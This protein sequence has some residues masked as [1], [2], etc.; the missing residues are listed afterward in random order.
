MPSQRWSQLS[1]EKHT[2]GCVDPQIIKRHCRTHT[3]AHCWHSTTHLTPSQ[4]T[5]ARPY[6]H[7]RWCFFMA[8]HVPPSQRHAGF[9][10]TTDKRAK[11]LYICCTIRRDSH[12]RYFTEV[13]MQLVHVFSNH[14]GGEKRL[15]ATTEV[16]A[17]QSLTQ[18][19]RAQQWELVF[20]RKPFRSF[21]KCVQYI[22]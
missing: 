13:S 9:F 3:H 17:K 22:F 15:C 18:S 19:V 10:C 4:N 2:A 8:E 1:A 14:L 20:N 12:W 21:W 6:T 11:I 16:T 7:K 5:Q